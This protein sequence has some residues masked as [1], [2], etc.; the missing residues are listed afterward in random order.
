MLLMLYPKNSVTI[1]VDPFKVIVFLVACTV[2]DIRFQIVFCT[3]TKNDFK[4]TFSFYF[5]HAKMFDLLNWMNPQ[6]YKR[7]GAG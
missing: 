4:N 3:T 2:L 1:S 5:Q 7:P 6:S